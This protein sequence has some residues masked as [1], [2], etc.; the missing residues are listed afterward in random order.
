MTSCNLYEET[1]IWDWR[2]RFVW[3]WCVIF[4]YVTSSAPCLTHLRRRVDL[5]HK[6]DEEIETIGRYIIPSGD[7]CGQQDL[8]RNDD[9]ADRRKRDWDQIWCLIVDKEHSQTNRI[10]SVLKKY[11]KLMIFFHNSIKYNKRCVD[12]AQTTTWYACRLMVSESRGY[13]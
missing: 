11:K 2:D 12:K 3:Y 8:W 13:D 1:L 9:V 5:L 4:V 6:L 7:D 10:E